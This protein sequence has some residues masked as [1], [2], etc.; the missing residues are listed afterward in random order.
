[1]PLTTR[2]CLVRHGET[3]W[4]AEQ[5]IQGHRD[6]P[7]N[8]VGLNQAEAAG[9][10]FAGYPADVLY[11]SDLQRARQTAAPIAAALRQPVILDPD[12]RERHFGRCEGLTRNELVAQSAEDGQALRTRDPDYQLPGGESLRQFQQRV[13]NALQQLI[14][15]HTGQ[16]LVLVTHGG[17][18]DIA[19]RHATGIGLEKPRD[20]AI[21]NAAI[22]WLA[23]TPYA[24]S[25]EH[26]AL[27][28]HLGEYA[29]IE[30]IGK[31]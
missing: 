4:N 25:V 12:L 28:A 18:L 29:S 21:P 14:D 31:L 10:Y 7:L 23:I 30:F 15:R 22:N 17:V 3:D 8:P 9:T 5:R 16:T 2:L 1:M 27:T 13:V 19:Y 6:Q 20:F 26:W 11:C 24:W